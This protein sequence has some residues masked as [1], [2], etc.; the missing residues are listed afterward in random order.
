MGTEAPVLT[1]RELVES[2]RL[3][4]FID[5]G[6]DVDT[7]ERLARSEADLHRV[8]SLLESGCSHELAA[9]IAR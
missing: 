6:Y 2:W 7:A 1:E 8:A 5:M 9:E 3:K 4:C